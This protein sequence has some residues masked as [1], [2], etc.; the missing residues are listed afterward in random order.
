MEPAVCSLHID[1]F[2]MLRLPLGNVDSDGLAGGLI[3]RLTK[4][5]R[6]GQRVAEGSKSEVRTSWN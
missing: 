4:T 5:I 6:H 2:G 3:D 1:D